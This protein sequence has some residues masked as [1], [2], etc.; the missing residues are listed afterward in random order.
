MLFKHK[1]NEYISMLFIF[2]YF[3]FYTITSTFLCGFLFQTRGGEP[4]GV[5]H[6]SGAC[7]AFPTPGGRGHFHCFFLKCQSVTF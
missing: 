3:H 4:S 7:H 6:R 1:K 5:V 2:L